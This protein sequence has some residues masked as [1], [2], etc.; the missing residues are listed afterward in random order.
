MN[1]AKV[2][3]NMPRRK[4]KRLNSAIGFGNLNFAS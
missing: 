2:N 1:S 3:K 4:G